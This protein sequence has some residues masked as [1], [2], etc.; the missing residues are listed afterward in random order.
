M[1][2][3]NTYKV[4]E[5]FY[6][7]Q[8]E[9]AQAG[10]PAVFCRFSGCNLWSGREED[11]AKAICQFCDTDFWGMDGENGGKYNAE[12]LADMVIGLWPGGSEKRKVKREKGKSEK[13]IANSEK[14]LGD[15]Y[16]LEGKPYVV[17]TGGEPLLQLDEELIEAFHA[18]GL[19]VAVETNGTVAA[20]A[21][22]DW[23]CMS[24]KA[25]TELLIQSGHELKLVYPQ[26]GAEPERYEHLNF[27]HFYLQPMDGPLGPQNTKLTL[28]YCMAHPKWK[29]SLQTHKI[30]GIA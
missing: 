13:R 9:G 16:V 23:I 1:K 22:L 19:E 11:R 25:N 26:P 3:R 5:I 21:G 15:T 4:K 30:L 17:C 28:E 8:G 14:Q 12:E 7:L 10:R 27:E 2:K 20:P 24:P 29:L 18:R 6:T